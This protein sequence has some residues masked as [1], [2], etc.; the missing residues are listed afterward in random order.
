M[1][2]RIGGVLVVV[3]F[4]LAAQTA[5]AGEELEE[6]ALDSE[7]IEGSAGVEEAEDQRFHHSSSL[8]IRATPIGLSYFSNTSHRFSL[9]DSESPLLDGTYLGAGA[10]TT[11]S[12][13]FGWFGPYVEVLPVAVLRLRASLQV[14]SYYGN[15]GYLYVPEDGET[16]DD[17]ALERAWDDS[18]G[19]S[20]T[21]WQAELEATPQLLVAGVV[22]TAETSMRRIDMGT[23]SAYYEPFLDLLFE[24]QDT[25]I[26]TR[27]TV[28]YLLGS[29]PARTHLLL[30]ARYE[31]AMVR[32][33]DIT[34]E[35]VGMVF[36][37]R[38]PPSIVE[39]GT[40]T[41]AGF[42]GLFMDH[43]TRGDWA[44]YSGMQASVEF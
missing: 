26:I 25:V 10:T 44:P 43:P 40:P 33:A 36:S 28:G 41:L 4:V 13:A 31:R 5:V 12:P 37:W 35:T 30:G 20:A 39:T 29:D 15:F 2:R 19:Q 23:E 14:M 24:P 17:D 6:A 38:M 21:G 42:G 18:L 22:F 9:W 8:Q 32:N 3:V 11:L 34:R 7:E 27:P 1:W 16:W